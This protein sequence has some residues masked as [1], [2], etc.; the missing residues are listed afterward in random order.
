MTI[1]C[2]YQRCML[3]HCDCV[4]VQAAWACAGLQQWCHLDHGQRLANVELAALVRDPVG[5]SNDILKAILFSL[6]QC[7]KLVCRFQ[8]LS[9]RAAASLDDQICDLLS[10][11]QYGMVM[12]SL[13]GC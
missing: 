12:C 4:S 2:V 7:G 5:V 11:A 13:M 10:S 6:E 3:C 9:W 8:S 1:R